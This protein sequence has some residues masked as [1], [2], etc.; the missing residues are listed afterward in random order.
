MR[1]I[2]LDKV[3][4]G[5]IIAADIFDNEFGGDLPV[6]GRGV[7][8]TTL[9]IEKLKDRGINEVTIVTPEGYQGAPGETLNP[10]VITEDITF[11]GAVELYC[12]IPKG[13]KIEAGETITI[14][15]NIASGCDIS[16]ANGEIIIVGKFN[17]TP[18]KHITISAAKK[19]TIK[20]TSIEPINSVDIRSISDVLIDGDITGSKVAAKGRLRIEGVVTNSRVYSQNRIRVTECGDGKSPCQLLVRPQECHGLFQEL[21]HLDS[22]N[23]DLRQEQERLQNTIDLIQQLGKDIESIPYDSKVQ[24]A[25]DIKRYRAIAEEIVSGQRQKVILKKKIAEILGSDRIFI[26]NKGN[27]K[28]RI[29]IE[30]YSLVLDAPVKATT[31]FVR[32]MKV[33]NA[34]L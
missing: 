32:E 9:F 1:K 4:S 17:G 12:D 26:T 13:T 34:P 28:T 27:P 18:D 8:L 25:M 29:T 22:E 14:N 15:G 6:I 7:E 20:N 11:I 33:E 16:S 2:S 21:L 31:F 24:M 3:K 19:V 10:S 23:S 30:N 5:M